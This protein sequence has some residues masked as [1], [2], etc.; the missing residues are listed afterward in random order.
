MTR[1]ID[2]PQHDLLFSLLD[3]LWIIYVVH[4]V[5]DP[6]VDDHVILIVNIEIKLELLKNHE[7]IV[8]AA[9][10]HTSCELSSDNSMS[11]IHSANNWYPGGPFDG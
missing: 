4:D 1:L 5:N 6:L 8:A 3:E 9:E 2:D 11:L 10:W 7:E